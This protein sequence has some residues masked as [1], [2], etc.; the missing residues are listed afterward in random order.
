MKWAKDN[1]R[2]LTKEETQMANTRIKIFQI[3]CY[4]RN[5]N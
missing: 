5:A 1:N 2:N 3:I 4:Q